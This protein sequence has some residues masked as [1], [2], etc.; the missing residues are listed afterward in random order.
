MTPWP[1]Q[2][3]DQ[4]GADRI[5]RCRKY[6]G[7]DVRRLLQ[8]HDGRSPRRDDDVDVEL[9]ELGCDFSKAFGM[10]LYPAI[11]DRY[12]ASLNPTEFAQSSRKCI[13][14]FA[15][16]RACVGDQKSDSR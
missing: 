5:A 1:R 4:T 14:P 11:L 12:G 9:D 3:G 2:T 8:R 6:D 13:D 15:S 7:N 16:G 10:S